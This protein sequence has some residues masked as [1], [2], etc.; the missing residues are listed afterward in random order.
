M[1]RLSLRNPIAILMLCVGLVVFSLVTTPRMSVDTFPELTPPVLVI[2]AV[3]PGLGP[4]DVEKTLAWPIETSV[5]ATPGVD[6]VQSLSRNNLALIFVWLNW[7]VDLNAAQGLVQQQVAFAMSTVPKTLGVLPPF[8]LQYDPSNQPV[9]QVAVSG[10]GL[11]GPQIYDYAINNIE[12][13]LEGIP[14]VASAAPNGGRVRQINVVVDPASSQA[15]AVT[16]SEVA[17]AVARSNALLPSGSFVSQHFDANVYTNAVAERI[18]SIAEGVVKVKDGRPVLIRDVARVED[19]ASPQT[20]AVSVNG[21][22]AVYLNVLRV[23][24]GNTL[25][26]VDAVKEKLAHLKNL[27]PGLQVKPIFDQSTYVRTTFAGLRREIIQALILISLVILLFLQELRAVLI[28]AIAIPISFAIILIVLYT[29]G[30]TLNAFTLG[31]LTLAM[32]PLVDISVVVLESIHRHRHHEHKGLA[33]A[34]RHGTEEVALPALAATLTT[35]AV[36]LPV[37]LLYGLA[38]KLFAPLALTVAVAMF[39]GYL[40]SMMVTPVAARAFLGKGHRG[41]LANKV[42]DAIHEVAN[43]YARALRATLAWR[44]WLVGAAAALIVASVL[45]ASHLPSTFFPEIDESMETVFL[46]LAPGTSLADSNRLVNDMARTVVQELPKGAVELQLANVGYPKSPR[47]AMGNPNN[48]P[49][50]AFM[51]FQLAG[52]EHRKLNQRQVADEIRRIL[53]R[54]YPGVEQIQSPGGLVANVFSNGYQAPVVIEL[55]G[56]DLDELAR[57]QAAVAEVAR[58]VAGVRDVYATLQTDYPEVRVKLDRQEAGL[59]GVDARAAAQ[60]TLESTYG[61]INAPSTW[62]DASNGMAYYVVTS[63][64]QQQIQDPAALARVPVRAGRNGAAV[65]LGAYSSI[66]RSLGPVAIERNQLQRVTHVL[67]Q[68]EGR[69]IGSAAAELERKL[70]ADPRTRGIHYHFAGQ[71][72]LMRDTFGGLGVAIGLA[73]MVVFMIMASQFKSLRLPLAMLF[74]IPCT[75]IGIVGAL[76]AAGQG[77]S[78]TALMGVLMVVGIAV[79]NGILLVDHAS[80][81]YARGLSKID[82]VVDAGRTRFVPILMTSL[83]TIIGLLPTALGLEA[84]AEANRP[85]A[86]AVVGGLASST[87]L[88]LFLV[89]AMFTLLAK[90][91]AEEHEEEAPAHPHPIPHLPGTPAT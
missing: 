45:A 12:P 17:A 67:M 72:Q 8:V 75:L 52:P 89:P 56:N 35:V 22:D 2:G 44:W 1:T 41:H 81:Q 25:Q 28:V 16:S 9:V 23:P 21:E 51:Q 77:F 58:G 15:R 49:H 70:A 38:K 24:G 69:D 82:A 63:Y 74:T 87:L 11:V 7:G 78:V 53:T 46:R 55:R 42:R 90:P 39:A 10:G 60:T 31:G 26:I 65:T 59:V 64:D 84:G 71:V 3:A 68:T 50:M 83:A 57:D 14:G 80:K 47:S 76:M 43:A 62:V 79:S 30:Q 37:L 29:T 32:G 91:P 5:S 86:L 54:R 40:V 88:S 36:L 13:V 6:H 85:L 4:K 48:G 20:Q 19:A 18:A 61:N 33:L 34:A 73:V 27:P 66:E